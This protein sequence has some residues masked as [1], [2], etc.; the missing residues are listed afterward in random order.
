MNI[1]EKGQLTLIRQ[2]LKVNNSATHICLNCMKV[3]DYDSTIYVKI[4]DCNSKN[5]II[6]D[7]YDYEQN[8]NQGVIKLIDFLEQNYC[9]KDKP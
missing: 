7:N 6:L 2:L 3:V 9:S 5:H 8:D 4:E 1:K